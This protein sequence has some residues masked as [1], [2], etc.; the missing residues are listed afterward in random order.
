MLG[1]SLVAVQDDRVLGPRQAIRDVV[2]RNIPSRRLVCACTGPHHVRLDLIDSLTTDD[3]LYDDPKPDGSDISTGLSL[4]WTCSLQC[5]IWLTLIHL[6]SLVPNSAKRNPSR[7][8]QAQTTLRVA[9]L[10]FLLGALSYV[11]AS[12]SLVL[13]T[14]GASHSSDPDR[15]HHWSMT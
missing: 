15:E 2:D 11:P 12:N 10:K 4:T 3:Q 8:Q 1:H 14:S 6:N 7:R 13:W 5:V 9:P